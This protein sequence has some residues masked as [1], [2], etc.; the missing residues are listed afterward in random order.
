M[1]SQAEAV[2]CDAVAP[3]Q[4]ELWHLCRD[5]DNGCLC[6]NH[7]DQTSSFWTPQ[8]SPPVHLMGNGRIPAGEKVAPPS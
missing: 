7:R 8:F 5:E 2:V 3:L 1:A 6:L 4:V